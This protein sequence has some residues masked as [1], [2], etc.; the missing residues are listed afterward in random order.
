MPMS[1]FDS[2]R[3]LQKMMHLVFDDAA[4]LFDWQPASL[5]HRQLPEVASSHESA[6]QKYS[7]RNLCSAAWYARWPT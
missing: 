3:P 4:V 5:L 6:D 1:R 2:G 7:C